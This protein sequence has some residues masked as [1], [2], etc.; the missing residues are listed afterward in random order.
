MVIL[1]IVS[2]TELIHFLP[3]GECKCSKTYYDTIFI[4]IWHGIF[5]VAR[6]TK[7]LANFQ[8]TVSSYRELG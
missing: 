6:L 8:V 4:I 7:T 1:T 3:L 2:A 5:R